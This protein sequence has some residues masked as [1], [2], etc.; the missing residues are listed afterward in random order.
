[1]GSRMLL[2]SVEYFSARREPGALGELTGH[3]GAKSLAESRGLQ[4]LKRRIIS[5]RD[6]D[7]LAT[8]KPGESGPFSR[9]QRFWHRLDKGGQVI[10]ILPVDDDPGSGEEVVLR[11]PKVMPE[12]ITSLA[13]ARRLA[14]TRPDIPHM[15]PLDRLSSGQMA[16]FSL[17]GPLVFRDQPASV[18][19]IDE[20]EQHLH[21]Q[22]QGLL[23]EALRELSPST[24]F[25]VA[26][27]S[28]DILDSVLSDE[29]FLLVDGRDPQA[30]QHEGFLR[31][32]AS[33]RV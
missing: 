6:R 7:L 27:H 24:L 1:M 30:L 15:V 18:V 29:C 22:W 16:I 33:A 21:V 2:P 12:D 10:D 8:R 14:P 19:V 28:E 11:E 25:I 26:T 23:L 17:A 4:E 20:P 13:M 5:A 3:G 31:A 32:D 9:I